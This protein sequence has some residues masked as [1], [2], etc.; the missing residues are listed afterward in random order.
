MLRT[1]FIE[2]CPRG[3]VV[4]LRES[5]KTILL[6]FLVPCV[7]N[8][9]YDTP[10]S[11]IFPYFQKTQTKKKISRVVSFNWNVVAHLEKKYSS[12][13]ID[14]THKSS[15]HKNGQ[16]GVHETLRDGENDLYVH[17]QGSICS[18]TC[19]KKKSLIAFYLRQVLPSDLW[20]VAERVFTALREDIR[21]SI[22]SF[23]LFSFALM[24]KRF[25]CLSPI[26]IRIILGSCFVL[27]GIPAFED[28]VDSLRVFDVN[29]DVLM[30]CAAVASLLVGSAFE[31]TL[32]V[33]L[34][35]FSH[36]AEN[37]V[38]ELARKKLDAIRD[39]TP[40]KALLVGSNEE[41]FEKPMD[42]LISEIKPGDWI[43]VKA[44]EI[45]PCDGI[46]RKGS[47]FITQEQ[48][49]G[50][51]TPYAAIEG[52]DIMSGSRTIDGS[53]IIQVS[54]LAEKST[55]QRIL[56][57]VTE[58]Q[59][60]R[61]SVQRFI[62]RFG[63]VYSRIVLTLSFCIIALLPPLSLLLK[64]S[65]V[66]FWG[67]GG[68]L[69]RGLAFLVTSSPCALMIGAPIA[70]L[71]C[72]SAAAARGV[73]I[74]GGAETIERASRCNHFAF[75]KTGTLTMGSVRLVRIESYS[76][77]CIQPEL[78]W[79][80][81]DLDE[82]AGKA[83]PSC[84]S[85]TSC[86]HINFEEVLSLAASLETGTVHPF[87][88][89][90]QSAAEIAKIPIERPL[91][92]QSF[93]GF[94]LHGTFHTSS[95]ETKSVWFGRL[96]FIKNHSSIER[97]HLEWLETRS[98][99]AGN[100]G[101]SIAVFA[102][103]FGRVALFCFMDK[104][105]PDAMEALMALHEQRANLTVVTGD[106]EAAARA[107]ID[108]L[109]VTDWTNIYSSLT[110]QA[111]L[112]LIR[113][114]STEGLIM[115]GDGINDAPALAAATTGVAMGLTSATAVQAAD[116]VL[117][118]PSLKDVVWL[119]NKSKHTNRIIIQSVFFGIFC[120][121]IASISSLFGTLPLWLATS[122]NRFFGRLLCIKYNS[123]STVSIKNLCST[124]FK[125]FASSPSWDL[126]YGLRTLDAFGVSLKEQTECLNNKEMIRRIPTRWKVTF[127]A[128]LIH[129]I[130]LA[131]IY[132]A[133]SVLLSPEKKHLHISLSE[134][135][136]PLNTYK[137]CN[138]IFL[139][140]VG[141]FI[142]KAG[143]RHCLLLGLFS[144]FVGGALYVLVP[145]IWFYTVLS[146]FFAISFMLAG[147]N[148]V[149]VLTCNWFSKSRG[150]AV[151]TVLAGYSCAASL[152]PI[153]LG[154]L[155][156]LWNYRV[157]YLC[158]LLIYS[159][160]ILPLAYFELHEN[161]KRIESTQENR[162]DEELSVI[163]SNETE[164]RNNEE[165]F[166]NEEDCLKKSSEASEVE[167]IEGT[168]Q[169]NDS[170]TRHT[171]S[172]LMYLQE[173]V[174]QTLFSWR[175]I[176]LALLYFS[177]QFALGFIYEHFVI[178]LEEDNDIRYER[179]TVYF[180]VLNICSFVS[181]VCSGYIADRTCRYRSLITASGAMF[182]TTL[183]LFRLSKSS[184]GPHILFIHPAASHA[185]FIVF[186][187]L[188]GLSLGAIFN[189]VYAIVPQ[190]L[191]FDHLAFAQSTLGALNFLGSALG[192]ACSGLIHD[193]THSYLLAL[194]LVCFS[195][196]FMFIDAIFVYS[197]HLHGKTWDAV[198]T[199][200]QE[201]D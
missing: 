112:D 106:T 82:N 60:N 99:E 122:G 8:R 179:A 43:L 147:T 86:G 32:L 12:A 3:H 39:C 140:F 6:R 26:W 120:M 51:T 149:I 176:A 143:L 135:T 184:K 46:V 141:L 80:I 85:N 151:G 21:I 165:G 164:N 146:V 11:Y 116:I 194:F 77:H 50:E 196:L 187:V 49:N 67:S 44:G 29:I 37:K 62:D 87:A 41:L 199:E 109:R 2:I 10:R 138:I 192:S 150:L 104:I 171:T 22:L 71:S 108:C 123:S 124:C 88:K 78:V 142:D 7:R 198:A 139:P 131:V 57:L 69:T 68:S 20:K 30:T 19:L 181:K 16:A 42:I 178:F 156:H 197:L 167:D 189:S 125:A 160:L 97:F 119:W 172:V 159:F 40:E 24:A 9:R 79:N 190:V 183:L 129:G 195:C 130:H 64:R 191:G 1:V 170:Q 182:I 136:V 110:P 18:T 91:R 89:A 4:C 59:Q 121:L 14:E 35:T 162:N 65:I 95:S 73:V 33:L 63:G 48:L 168:E 137:L 83:I 45:A 169:E 174:F 98:A 166:V 161:P 93:S 100:R 84:D 28:A 102:D 158:L 105:R 23:I 81:S 115:V 126:S 188:F 53:L 163:V 157:A 90:I 75:D 148:V 70:Y 201:E 66:P 152:V 117:V 34:Y 101:E 133:P 132:I 31:G 96:S 107:V 185:Q 25:R 127:S 175:F 128:A 103:S 54:K 186:C 154:R 134:A 17:C 113:E 74:K 56:H 72:L 180:A 76:P 5:R 153:L 13:S 177:L 94:G 27:N 52:S 61:P 155:V 173:T 111:K 114:W 47:A 92:Y 36:I 193:I 55:L 38:M 118:Q 145:S 15:C 200:E 144:G 58:A